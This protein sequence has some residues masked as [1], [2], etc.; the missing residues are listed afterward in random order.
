MKNK[1]CFKIYFYL[2]FWYLEQ[3]QLSLGHMDYLLEKKG[4][5]PPLQ[6]YEHMMYA[7]KCQEF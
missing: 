6:N 2:Q 1:A 7:V 4:L 5:K 3:N